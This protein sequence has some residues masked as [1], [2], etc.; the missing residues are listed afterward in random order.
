[1]SFIDFFHHMLYSHC[2]LVLDEF[3]KGKTTRGVCKDAKQFSFK[4][5]KQHHYLLEVGDTEP[6]GKIWDYR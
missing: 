6:Q 2:L 5:V 1:M 4:H 3:L